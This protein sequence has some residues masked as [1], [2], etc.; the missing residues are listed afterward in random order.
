MA[1]GEAVASGSSQITPTHILIALSK[2]SEDQFQSEG[3][4]HGAA[5]RREFESMGIEPRRLRRR[6]RA[7]LPNDK[8][9]SSG[10][11]VHRSET[12]KAVFGLAEALAKA[13][14][15]PS[16]PVHLLRAIFLLL[17]D[18]DGDGANGTAPR[19]DDRGASPMAE[20]SGDQAT[21]SGLGELTRRL[22][23]LRQELLGRVQ[24]QN[25]AVH[26]F[27]EGL[28]NVE[29]VARVDADRRKPAGLFVFA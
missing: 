20:Q 27:V 7:L 15:E 23:T 17:G 12:A 18:A 10:S 19:E 6:L 14:A 22:R 16:G 21:P 25:H 4:D 28:F 9:G 3:E 2:L 26:Q 1:A 24:G 11:I 29:V 5:L 13:S 8:N